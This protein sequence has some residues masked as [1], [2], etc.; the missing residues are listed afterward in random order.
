[1]TWGN[2]GDGRLG[3]GTVDAPDTT[4]RAEPTAVALDGVLAASFGYDHTLVLLDDG[5]VR[6]FGDNASGQLGDGST[7]DRSHPVEVPGLADVIQVVGGSKHSVALLR[8]GTVWAWGRNANGNLGGGTTDADPHPTPVQVPD[9]ADVVHLASGRDHVLALRADGTVLAWG[10][11]QSG[12][13]GS[14]LGGDEGTSAT[15]APV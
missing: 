2:N 13:L 3:L 4:N 7:E 6:A 9:V 5:T 12:Q 8:D 1:L 10:L 14:G 15:P 11:G